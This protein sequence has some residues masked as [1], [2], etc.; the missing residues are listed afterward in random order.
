MALVRELMKHHRQLFGQ[1]AGKVS[2]RRKSVLWGQVIVAVNSEGVVR[3]TEDTCRKRF[4]DIKRRVKAK[5]AKEA[6]SARKTGGGPPFRATYREWEEPV[7]A[8]IP[9]EVVS[10]THVRDSDRPTQ[11]VR[12][13]SRPDRPQTTQDDAGIA[14]S[15][16][17]SLPP[18]RRPSQGSGHLPR[19]PSKTRR[20]GTE[21]AAPSSP[22]RRRISAVSPQPPLALLASPQSD[23]P[24]SPQLSEPSLMADVDQQGQDQQATFTLQLTP[25]DP[26]QP[27]QLQ[28]IPQASMS[29]QLAQAPPQPQIPDDFWSSWTSQHAQSNASLTAHTQHLASLPHHLPRISRNSGRLI[30]QVGRIATSM[31]QIRADNNQMLAHL[32]R[33]IDE[34]QRHQQTL[35]QLI[36]HNQVVNESLSRIVASHTATNTQLNASINNLSN[37]ITLMAA[38]QVT[39]SSGTTT[40]IQTPVTSPVRRSSRARA[41]EP[42]QSTAPSTH[43]RKK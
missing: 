34:Q 8:L 24:R 43:K 12:Q 15:A 3:R 19:R 32:T 35:V 40:P 29:P 26:S 30:V 39:S 37:N 22:P 21:S 17:V 2:S 13:T 9:A 20:L 33:I 10:A 1:D 25:V 28:D 41:S 38:Q 11:D 16:S 42:A 18:L 14:G 5:M 23:E 31:E 27:I 6:K 7:R 4:Y 36:Q